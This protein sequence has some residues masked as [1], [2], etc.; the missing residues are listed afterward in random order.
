[1]SLESIHKVMGIPR[2]RYEYVFTV[3]GEL[4]RRPCGKSLWKLRVR[5]RPCSKWTFIKRFHIIDFDSVGV[6]SH[7][8]R[9]TRWIKSNRR[10]S[11][12]IQQPL[13]F[14]ILATRPTLHSYSI[15]KH[16]P[17]KKR[18]A[19]PIIEPFHPMKLK[20]KHPPKE[21]FLLQ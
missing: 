7:S 6:Q 2:S 19:N 3:I 9:Q 17:G 14:N 10:L 16:V 15:E 18:I 8:K 20:G 4:N 12:N 11:T 13:C 1:M 21:T 5:H